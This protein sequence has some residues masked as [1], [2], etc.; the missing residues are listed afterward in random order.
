MG[1]LE[2]AGTQPLT[3]RLA[4]AASMRTEIEHVLAAV[5]P[6]A[7]PA[8]FRAAIL[9][10]NAARK[11]TLT[12]RDWAWKRLKL[13]YAL[14]SPDT[15]EFQSFV[16]EMR[17]PDTAGRGLIAYLMLAR[18]DR[19]FREASAELLVPLLG[20]PDTTIE[21]E[22][23]VDYV[24]AAR[25]AVELDWSPKSVR[26]IAGHILTSWKEF[27]LVEGSKT[28]RVARLRPSHATTRFVIALARADGLTD[29]QALNSQWAKLLGMDVADVEAALRAA[30]RDG[31]LQFR[32]QADVIEIALPG[33]A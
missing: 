18:T 5:G 32:T 12:A 2:P 26:A 28:R 8:Q 31:A 22:S 23:V 21:L 1:S 10:Q 27:G 7:T 29:R 17:D 20:T 30:A 33:G 13:R 4:G 24:D 15:A 3:A 6:D 16:R 11:P 14:D 25:T 9:D 19:L